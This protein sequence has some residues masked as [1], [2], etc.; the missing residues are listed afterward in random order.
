L[1]NFSERAIAF[2]PIRINLIKQIFFV[3]CSAKEPLTQTIII[4]KRVL[5]S[6]GVCFFFLN[7]VSAQ[8]GADAGPDASVCRGQGVFLGS[9]TTAFSGTPPYTYQWS[10]Y[11]QST[12]GMSQP[13]NP[14]E[15][16]VLATTTYHLTVT[17]NT[18][19]QAFDTVTITVLP[20]PII[21]SISTDVAVGCVGTPVTFSLHFTGGLAPLAY[22]WL[23]NST[24]DTS[25]LPNP[26][27]VFPAP[28]SYFVWGGLQGANGCSATRG[29]NMAIDSACLGVSRINA[30]CLGSCD[31]SATVNPPGNYRYLWSNGDS[32][33]SATAL[34][35]GT[36]TV[37]VM[38][39]IFTP[40]DTLQ[41][42][43]G[44]NWSYYIYLT[45]AA[46]NCS[47][48]GL[49]T[50]TGY[51]G[52]PPYTYLWNTT[53]S[54]TTQSITGLASGIYSVTVSD[55][56]GC[57]HEGHILVPTHCYNI[58]QGF[59]FQDGNNNCIKD[60]GEAVLANRIVTASGSGGSFYA[61]SDAKGF[62]SINVGAAG[63]FTLIV[64][65]SWGNCPGGNLCPQ[66]VSFGGLGDSTTTNVSY[67]VGGFNLSI[68]PGWTSANP[69]F[70]KDY[71]VLYYQQSLPVYAGPATIVFK[72][73]SILVF[74]SCTNGGVND[75]TA[76]TI[77][78][79]VRSVPYPNWDWNTV[80][81]AYFT[82]PV[83]T[84]PGYQLSQEFWISPTSGDCDSS[85]NHLL[86]I[87]PVTSSMDPN[88]KEVSPAGDIMEEDSVLTYTIHFQN[89][90]NDTT[91]FVIVKDTL[92]GFVDPATVQNI[93][94]SHEYS[95]FDIS[96]KGIL[97]WVFNPI[98]LVDS[99]TNAAASKGYVMFK[100]KKKNNLAANTLIENRA[101][102][103]FDYNEP[104]VTNTVTNT[105]AL[106][107]YIFTVKGDENISV[108]AMPNPFTQS[109]QIVV[110]GINSTYDFELFDVTGKTIKKV[111]L[112]NDNRFDLNRETMNTGVYF[113][114]ITTS[115][116]QRAYGRV[117]VE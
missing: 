53:P 20:S 75:A 23:V 103:Y 54:Q 59:L 35:V 16:F 50:A 33:I 98:Y 81:R 76:H 63:S 42:S 31:G 111:S 68:H 74:Q 102:I 48:S 56:L 66:S 58:V 15:E 51:G 84:P 12:S 14:E 62:F 32:T 114:R 89:T 19:A 46:S 2:E 110:N 38:D 93:S 117:V 25:N 97:T 112:L 94:S 115:L 95:S 9:S 43:I 116:K 36:Y 70:A 57:A 30:S 1:L 52:T 85:N 104:V 87:Q 40:L 65:N 82:V 44:T 8:L 90:G 10:P 18:G 22:F 45:S 17:D 72:Y 73:D 108:S 61:Y 29:F 24:Q 101:H 69:G 11:P 55:S 7:H 109:T 49:A 78:W 91:W 37:T 6:L 88:E 92:G 28:G 113:Y 34:C 71:W 79:N 105:V 21:D 39:S 47:P 86:A 67:D 13:S 100:V 4:M 27:F 26:Q 60:S 107:N 41:V 5:L 80:P 64:Q 83:N 96:D 99:M 77:T 106:P 3:T